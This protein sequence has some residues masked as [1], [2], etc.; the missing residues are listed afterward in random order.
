MNMEEQIKLLE[1]ESDV[2]RLKCVL[3][4]MIND[5]YSLSICDGNRTE[6]SDELQNEIVSWKEE[7]EII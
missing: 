4:T 5:M 1:L 7:F 6:F 3:H 2:K